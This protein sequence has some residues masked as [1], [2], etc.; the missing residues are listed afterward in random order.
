MRVLSFNVNGIR[1]AAGKGLAPYLV[2]QEADVICLQELRASREDVPSEL[3][4]LPGYHTLW[5]CSERKGYSGVA[6][7]SRQPPDQTV[8]GMEDEQTHSEGRLLR[9]D[10]GGLSI[11]SLYVPSG[12]TGPV[13][14]EHKMRFL[15]RFWRTSRTSRRK[16]ARCSSAVTSISRTKPLTSLA[17]RRMN[18]RAGICPRSA[19]GWT[20]CWRRATWISIGRS[21]AQRRGITRGGTTSRLRARKIW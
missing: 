16:A 12:I 13:R 11:L 1:A 18:T 4:S 6:L 2:A 20:I 7:L 14:Q 17:P 15:A 5:H 19:D 9:A 8:Y 21:S 3:S 10:F